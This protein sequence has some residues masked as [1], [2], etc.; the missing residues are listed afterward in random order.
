MKGE[1]YTY[2]GYKDKYENREKL[3]GVEG[4][5]TNQDIMYEK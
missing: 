3:G 4:G 1:N 5:Q 2:H